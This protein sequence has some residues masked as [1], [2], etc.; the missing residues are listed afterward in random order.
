MVENGNFTLTCSTSNGS[1]EFVD[2]KVNQN[3][4]IVDKNC[5]L[6][7]GL[8]PKGATVSCSG[9]N[10]FTV[11]LTNVSRKNTG[12]EWIC[13]EIF[14]ASLYYSNVVTVYV[15]GEHQYFLNDI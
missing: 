9:N 13:R 8:P 7:E 3:G 4:F 6:L 12:D 14:S 11:S 10:M 5:V 15:Y 2:W 1:T